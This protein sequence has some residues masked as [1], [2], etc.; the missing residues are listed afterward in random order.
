MLEL[1]DLVMRPVEVVGD[2][3]YLLEQGIEGVAQ[4]PPRPICSA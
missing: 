2:K 3:G 1:H 4:D